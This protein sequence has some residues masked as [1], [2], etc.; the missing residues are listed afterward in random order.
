MPCE[1]DRTSR[2]RR[3]D[4]APEFVEHRL[5]TSGVGTEDPLGDAQL[6]PQRDQSLLRAV[7][8]VALDT[9]T[10]RVD[11]GD[12]SRTRR[13]HRGL[14]A[15]RLESDR[16]RRG[17]GVEQLRVVEQRRVVREGG[18]GFAVAAHHGRDRPAAAAGA[19]V[20]GSPSDPA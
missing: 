17:D 2:E 6:H 8:E 18:D 5:R 13:R 15:I 10:R 20:T 9:P 1:T 4:V 7:V 3:V 19:A 14:E 16:R 11:G 12:G